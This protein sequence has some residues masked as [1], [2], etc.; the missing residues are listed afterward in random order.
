MPRQTER[1]KEAKDKKTTRGGVFDIDDI[2][3]DISDEHEI[4]LD[5]WSQDNYDS[6][7]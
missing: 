7:Y 4:D 1:N 2:P 5:V 3:R 6:N